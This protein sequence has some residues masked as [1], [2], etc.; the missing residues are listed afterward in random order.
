[1]RA[2]S[3][4][5][6]RSNTALSHLIRCATRSRWSHVDF[7]LS[8]RWCLGAHPTQGVSYYE[9]GDDEECLFVPLPFDLARYVRNTYGKPYDW[10]GAFNLPFANPGV[11]DFLSQ[12]NINLMIDWHD[13][14]AWFCSEWVALAL[15]RAELASFPTQHHVT[16]EDIWLAIPEDIRV[17]SYA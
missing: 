14:D 7:H 4:R 11:S 5:F 15:E 10:L 6:A 13:P 1:M 16:P 3:I 17:A 9:Y 8:D 2:R 12:F